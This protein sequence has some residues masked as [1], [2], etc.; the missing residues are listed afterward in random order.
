MSTVDV[1]DIAGGTWYQQPT[2][3]GPGA[4]G[5]G[6]AVVAPAQ[7][8]S[9]FSIYYY[10][11]F[12]GIDVEGSFSDD[13]WILSLPSFMWM[14][15]YSGNSTHARAGH[16]CVKPYP[17]QM[18]VIG[19]YTTESGGSLS[20]IEGGVIQLFNLSS[21]SWMTSYNSSV[22]SEYEVPSMI[23]VMIG[24][25]GTGGATM[26][27]PTPTGWATPGLAS[28]FA[29]P[30]PTS[31]ITTYYPYGTSVSNSTLPPYT[32]TSGSSVPKYL[33]PLLGVIFGLMLVTAIAAAIIIWRRRRLL[34][35]GAA[36]ESGT[37]ENGNRILSWMRG[38]QSETKAPTVTTEDTPVSPEMDFGV[39][40]PPPVVHH[41]MADTQVAELMG[42]LT[43]LNF[44]LFT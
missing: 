18:M 29:T 35:N 20:C 16:Q 11:G 39:P 34:R 17:D 31:K 40:V 12:N 27:T 2:T 25:T 9:S 41:E 26:T 22:W 43:S 13:V 24:G 7:D 37:D 1:Y 19:G 36:S 42:K 6:C 4:L 8:Y 30:Y 3:G 15:V 21:V 23:Y 28:V 14:K 10:G 5:R 38:Q 32:T 33:P 44:S